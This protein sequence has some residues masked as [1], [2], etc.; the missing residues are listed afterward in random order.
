MIFFFFFLDI[1]LDNAG[2][3]LFTDLCLADYLVT[4]KFVNTVRF[5][6]KAIPWFVSDVTSQDF[7]STIEYIAYKNENDILK[8]LGKRWECYVK[9]GLSVCDNI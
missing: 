9:S 6:G 3:E 4:Y 8:G 5:H 7:I 1:I 2:Y